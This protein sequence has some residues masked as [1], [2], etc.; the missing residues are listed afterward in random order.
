MD[1]TSVRPQLAAWARSVY[2]RETV[3]ES[4][5]AMP[6]HSGYSYGFTLAGPGVAERFV[7]RLPPPGSKQT[8]SSDV[9]HQARV[10]EAM[11]RSGVPV[12]HIVHAG[13]GDQWF[14]TPY[15]VASWVEGRSTSLYREQTSA[16][17]DGAGLAPVFTSAMQTLAAIHAADWR[18]LLPDWSEPI[19]LDGEI[20]KWQ[21]TLHKSHNEEWI[22]RGTEL[23]RLLDESRPP[24]PEP[25]VVHGDYYSNNWLFD[26]ERVTAVVDWEIS[27]IGATALDIGWTLFFWDFDAWGPSRHRWEA[28]RPDLDDLVEAYVRAAGREVEHLAWYRALALYRMACI[29]ARAWELHLAGKHVDPA[30]EIGAE[31]F[32]FQIAQA[33]R[34]LGAR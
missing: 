13:D 29:T 33:R 19:D 22:R 17:E 20:A 25:G 18:S 27:G 1:V 2:G 11:E 26:D 21:P 15:F 28:W 10:M 9:L 5:A 34:L 24:E 8:G 3:V 32:P 16:D 6:G 31:A 7:V 23:A 4:V 12:P 30:W 14:G